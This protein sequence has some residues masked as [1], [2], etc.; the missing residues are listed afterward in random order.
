MHGISLQANVCS[1]MFVDKYLRMRNHPYITPKQKRS[2]PPTVDY[3]LIVCNFPHQKRKEKFHTND[4]WS[5]KETYRI[6]RPSKGCS[7][8]ELLALLCMVRE[9]APSNPHPHYSTI[10]PHHPSYTQYGLFVSSLAPRH[11][12]L[13]H[14]L[15]WS[16]TSF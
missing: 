13:R 15:H 11:E 4:M 3:G 1:Q 12:R 16:E 8:N 6:F 5:K 2:Q 10:T 7:L 9:A 14:V